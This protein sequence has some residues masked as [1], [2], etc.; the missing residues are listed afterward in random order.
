MGEL[1]ELLE[2]RQASPEM[3]E[4]DYAYSVFDAYIMSRRSKRGKGDPQPP[5][6][7]Y[8]PFATA[9]F[10]FTTPKDHKLAINLSRRVHSYFTSSFSRMPQLSKMPRDPDESSQALADRMS[11][12]LDSVFT[13]SRVKAAQPRSASWLSNRGDTVFGVEWDPER[14]EVYP[15]TY[16]P[17]WCYP[18]LDP[19]DLGGVADMLITFTVPRSYAEA[20]YHVKLPPSDKRDAQVYIYW[21]HRQ[22]LVEVDDVKSEKFSFG[23]D[24]QRCPFRWVFGNSD[25]MYAQSDI[26]DVPA[27]QDFYNEN[28]ILAMDSIRKQVDASWIIFGH[29]KELIPQPG[30][31]IGVP[32]ADAKLQRLEAGADPQVIMSVMGM[33]ES[34]VES[35]TGLSP[36]S[37]RGQVSGSG[38]SG[39]A[40]RN[41][42]QA[43][44]ARNE[45]R[46]A[47][48]EDAYEQVGV[49]CLQVL[50]RCLKGP[51]KL[52][53]RDENKVYE[54]LKPE[55]VDGHYLCEATYGGFIGMA[56]EQRIQASLQGLGRIYGLSTAVRLAAI[57]GASPAAIEKEVAQYQKDLAIQAASAQ[58]IAQQVGQEAKATP[59]DMG[60]QPIPSGAMPQQQTP[61]PPPGPGQMGVISLGDIER[62][63]EAAESKLHGSVW[64]VGEIAVVGMAARPQLMVSSEKDLAVVRSLM[65]HLR[66]YVSLGHPGDELPS[67]Q[68]A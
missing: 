54:E 9:R 63:L 19:F 18:T 48:F 56:L 3:Y 59:Q 36:V 22:R 7:T 64:A 67:L 58:A 42:V 50:E 4:R 12:W 37:S 29:N 17:A 27:L 44:E 21:D 43:M 46:K 51:I 24:L 34:G 32:R 41:Q 1:K 47:A 13:R 10:M 5:Q 60:Q 65:Q 2:H 62:T 8:K 11:F 14:N 52:D 68:V 33:L 23:H 45:A 20:T 16:D 38:T 49:L 6:L 26:R 57:P 66:T 39:A 25:G 61:A 30:K 35:S 15:R 55:D 40:V 28:L 53:R 31:A